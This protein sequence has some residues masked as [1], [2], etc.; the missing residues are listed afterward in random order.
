[1]VFSHNLRYMAPF[2]FSRAGFCM[3]FQR[4][5]FVFSCPG[6][7]FGGW[8]R[9]LDPQGQN[10]GPGPFLVPTN[11]PEKTCFVEEWFCGGVLGESILP[12]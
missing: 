2:D 3:V 5:S 9:I 12:K 8:G 1:M 4:A 10:F 7:D 11:G 6:T